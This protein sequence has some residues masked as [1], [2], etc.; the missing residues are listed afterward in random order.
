MIHGLQ[1]G[2][3]LIKENPDIFWGTIMSMYI[4]NVI[5]IIL[6][7]PLVGLWVKLLKIPYRILFPLI[8]FFCVIGSYSV[9][10]STFDVFM[11]IIFG[12]IGYIFRKFKYEPA[13]LVMG[14]IL[15]DLLEESLRQS[16]LI[17]GGSLTLFFVRPI[18]VSSLIIA[19]LISLFPIFFRKSRKTI[20][21]LA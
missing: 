2:P 8:F 14:F 18:S 12:I 10:N 17:S 16:I 21:E 19:L 15:G 11:M 3:L 5:L 7:L 4:G 20:A 6:N 9:N 13:P 1:P